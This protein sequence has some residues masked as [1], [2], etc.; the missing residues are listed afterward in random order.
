MTS[1]SEAAAKDQQRLKGDTAIPQGGGESGK[2]DTTTASGKGA[3]Q[4]PKGDADPNLKP[5]KPGDS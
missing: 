5:A 1:E 4:A 2:Q 3:A